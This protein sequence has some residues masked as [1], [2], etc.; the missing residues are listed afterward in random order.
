MYILT[1]KSNKPSLSQALSYHIACV[2]GAYVS[3]SHIL[4]IKLF[5]CDTLLGETS[6]GIPKVVWPY[7]Q[8]HWFIIKF[9][10]FKY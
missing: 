2:T 7:L 1:N 10:I 4:G 8:Y 9:N 5:A 3:T 6:V